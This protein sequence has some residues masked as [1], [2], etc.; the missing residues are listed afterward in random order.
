MARKVLFMH[1]LLLCITV[2]GQS[3]KDIDDYAAKSFAIRNL[4]TVWLSQALTKG[5]DNEEDKVRA[6]YIWITAHIR[7]DAKRFIKFKDKPQTV[8]Q[9]LRKRKGICSDYSNLFLELCKHAKIKAYPIEGYV[10]GFG[11]EDDD[12]AFGVNHVWNM[13]EI[14]GK[15]RLLDLTLASGYLI[16]VPY[17]HEKLVP[18]QTL[19][20]VPYVTRSKLVFVKERNDFF[21]FTDPKLFI[22][23]HLPADPTFQL[24][25]HPFNTESF[26][27]CNKDSCVISVDTSTTKD[28]AHEIDFLELEAPHHRNIVI[29]DSA[30]SFSCRNKLYQAFCY[31]NAGSMLLSGKPDDIGVVKEGIKYLEL[32]NAMIKEGKPN[33]SEDAYYKRVKNRKRYRL[34]Q[35][36]TTAVNRSINKVLNYCSGKIRQYKAKTRTLTIANAKVSSML[37]RYSNLN[38]H[39]FKKDH[40]RDTQN[41]EQKIA[42]NNAQIEV[43][44]RHI[45]Q[46]LAEINTLLKELIKA[47]FEGEGYANLEKQ[48]ELIKSY[49]SLILSSRKDHLDDLDMPY[50]IANRALAKKELDSIFKDN[51]LNANHLAMNK[52]NLFVLVKKLGRTVNGSMHLAI[53]NL[54]YGLGD[55]VAFNASR[56]SIIVKLEELERINSSF[57]NYLDIELFYTKRL[58]KI[59]QIVLTLLQAEFFYEK[60]RFKFRNKYITNYSNHKMREAIRMSKQNTKLLYQ[61]K[62]YLAGFNI[63]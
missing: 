48:S 42:I 18:I 10:K 40:I 47:D 15:W 34:M 39:D 53:K 9:T 23:D 31:Y 35:N 19:Y 26:E 11:H 58:V 51:Y 45:N 16:F 56:D 24:L 22:I 54:N 32:S 1:F 36:N 62:R 4:N 25:H 14:N 59:N 13:V 7:Y 52:R 44:A 41:M 37:D 61:A 21:Y 60:H 12:L 3:G 29:G 28:Y 5:Y 49:S 8:K 50:L 55:E 2:T 30:A 63:K 20:I 57:Q 43:N 27:R 33:I 38:F 46:Y 6:I 17:L